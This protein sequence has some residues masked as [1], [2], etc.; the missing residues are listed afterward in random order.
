VTREEMWQQ[1]RA[2]MDSFS[3][4]PEYA[5]NSKPACTKL[6]RDYHAQYVSPEVRAL[7]ARNIPADEL[8]ASR[9]PYF[10]DILMRRWDRMVPGLPYAVVTLLRQNGDWLSP[11]TGV[12]ILKE[13]ARQI[14]EQGGAP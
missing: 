10:N 3:K 6:H 5:V 12:C 11:A 2:I 7:V 14:V 8:R 9:D 4:D 1:H 13:A